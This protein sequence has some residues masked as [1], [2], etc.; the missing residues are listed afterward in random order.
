MYVSH[1][2][3]FLLTIHFV[4]SFHFL[5][6]IKK[7]LKFEEVGMAVAKTRVVVMDIRYYIV[8]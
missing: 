3:N 6:S 5:T 4:R 7:K 8:I 1:M 2:T